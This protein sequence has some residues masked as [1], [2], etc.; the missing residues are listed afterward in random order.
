[1]SKRKAKSLVNNSIL[2]DKNRCFIIFFVIY[3][4]VSESTNL[5]YY[6]RSRDTLV[7]KKKDYCK[8]N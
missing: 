5:T 4:K 6:Q 2:I 8:N 3:I 7:N 1:M